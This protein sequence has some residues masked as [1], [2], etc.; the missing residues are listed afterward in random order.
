MVNFATLTITTVAALSSFVVADN[1]RSGLAYCG[2]T[3]LNMGNYRAQIKDALKASGRP[4]TETDIYES[5]F[6][7]IDGNGNIKFLKFCA[8]YSG[9]YDRGRGKDDECFT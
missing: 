2:L 8:G 4:T 3:L 1:C 6:G 9:C 5:L 7:C